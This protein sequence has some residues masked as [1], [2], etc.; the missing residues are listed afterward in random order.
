MAM[1]RLEEQKDMGLMPTGPMKFAQTS[2]PQQGWLHADIQLYTDCC[3]TCYLHGV[4]VITLP[5]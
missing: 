4:H 3:L 5:V 1:K 2:I